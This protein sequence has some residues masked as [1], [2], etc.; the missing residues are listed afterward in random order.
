MQTTKG[1]KWID[2]NGIERDLD[3]ELSGKADKSVIY[4][5][6]IDTLN[7][8]PETAVEYT[9]DAVGF[10]PS[11]GNSGSY[12]AGDI[13]GCFPWNAIRPCVLE[14]N[15]VVS[16]YLDPNDFTQFE[17]GTPASVTSSDMN[18]VMIEIPHFW[19][20]FGRVG[21]FVEVKVSNAALPGY[22]DYAFR[23]KGEV[24]DKFYIGAYLGFID[25]ENYLRSISGVTP[26]GNVDIRMFR[27][28]AQSNG[29]GYE[30]LSFNKLT[31][32]QVLYLLQFKSLDSQS[33]LGLGW[34]YPSS[35][36]VTGTTDQRGMNYGHT[37]MDPLKFNGIEDF[38]GNLSQFV[39]GYYYDYYSGIYI[40]DGNYN[41][42]GNGYVHYTYETNMDGFILDVMGTNALGFTPSSDSGSSWTYYCD[43]VNLSDSGLLAYGGGFG[44]TNNA[45]AFSL[46]TND[47]YYSDMRTGVRLVYCG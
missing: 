27:I 11:R 47:S 5:V 2:S 14:R 31:A 33:A 42:T 29:E 17:D 3:T 43:Y 37:G 36:H 41:D 19:Y 16:G 35:V 46:T 26:R 9:D 21:D 40:A 10:T 18:D 1:V 23:Y 32:L 44:F 39:D 20:K 30:Q 28:A 22:T 12:I 34:T 13:D 45:G 7:N 15:G 38:W 25:D 4:G 6:R 8:N 24:K